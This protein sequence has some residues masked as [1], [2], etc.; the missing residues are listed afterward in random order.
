MRFIKGSRF[1]YDS[2]RHEWVDVDK[3]AV[4]GRGTGFSPEDVVRQP[5]LPSDEESVHCVVCGE[6]MKSGCTCG[7]WTIGNIS[8]P[9]THKAASTRS[10]LVSKFKRRLCPS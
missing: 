2:L 8:S 9:E 5:V 3:K 4:V 6:L 7:R 1:T 10:N